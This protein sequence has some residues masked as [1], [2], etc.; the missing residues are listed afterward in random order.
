MNRQL[1]SAASKGYDYL[2]RDPVAARV[3]ASKIW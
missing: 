2:R 1:P 3:A